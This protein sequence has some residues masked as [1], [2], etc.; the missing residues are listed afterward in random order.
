MATAH[1]GELPEGTKRCVVCGEPINIEARKC[2]HCTSEQWWWRRNV[3]MSSTVLSLLVALVAVLGALIPP[4]KEAFTAKNSSL[5]F[6]YQA[7]DRNQLVVFVS[8]TG[9]RAGSLQHVWIGDSQGSRYELQLEV[10]GTEFVTV[11]APGQT[12]LVHLRRLSERVEASRFTKDC[13]L[14]FMATN[15]TGQTDLHK[16]P[17]SC[18]MVKRFA[19]N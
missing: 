4:L 16:L 14:V 13:Y 17:L 15:F 2:I 6:S 8:N 1:V 10:I 9:T 11:V 12:R 7:G 5:I 3:L 18:D 19:T